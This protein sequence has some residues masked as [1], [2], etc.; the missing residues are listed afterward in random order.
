MDSPKYPYFCWALEYEYS[1]SSLNN[2][3]ID[4][5]KGKDKNI[6]SGIISALKFDKVQFGNDNWEFFVGTANK[7]VYENGY[8]GGG[9]SW[10]DCNGKCDGNWT[11]HKRIVL[12]DDFVP[13]ID[14]SEDIGSSCDSSCE[15]SC[16]SS[17]DS[18]DEWAHDRI[19]NN[20]EDSGGLK[21]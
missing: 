15:S 17:S 19:V 7:K 8:C 3:F 16:K 1:D 20:D 4:G 5:F 9:D 10:G 21:L 18:D 14:N 13:L 2:G 12:I 6:V 11:E